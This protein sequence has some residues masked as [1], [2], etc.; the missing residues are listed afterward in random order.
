MAGLST[1]SGGWDQLT[2]PDCLPVADS[3]FV[4]GEKDAQT[5]ITAL[6][7]ALTVAYEEARIHWKSNIFDVPRGAV[8][9][10]FVSMLT[11]LFHAI[12]E[13]SAL[14]SISLKAV[15]IACSD[16]PKPKD[17]IFHLKHFVAGW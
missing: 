3:N 1:S 13:D 2:L 10:E 7:T 4:L 17:H 12:E 5:L 8:G 14:A 15:F 11:N 6:V 16:L 9:K